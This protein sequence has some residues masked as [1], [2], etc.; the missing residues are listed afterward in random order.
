MIVNLVKAMKIYC[1]HSTHQGETE[2]EGREM[3]WKAEKRMK[4]KQ[5]EVSTSI[6]YALELERRR[7]GSSLNK[8][9]KISHYISFIILP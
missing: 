3:R 2:V 9:F 8:I 5:Y 7:R 1:K 6:C 4:N